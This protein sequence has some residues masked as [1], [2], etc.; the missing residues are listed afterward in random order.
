MILAL[1]T[2]SRAPKTRLLRH[3]SISQSCAKLWCQVLQPELEWEKVQTSRATWY[4]FKPVGE[5]KCYQMHFIIHIF[6]MYF[7]A[8]ILR[9]Q[10]A[11]CA[12]CSMINSIDP[13]IQSHSIHLIH[14]HGSTTLYPTSILPTVL[15]QGRKSLRGVQSFSRPAAWRQTG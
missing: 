14:P 2:E 1:P 7:S 10:A 12:A 8:C 15:K 9:I 5:A 13:D 11:L 6:M 3:T 4:F